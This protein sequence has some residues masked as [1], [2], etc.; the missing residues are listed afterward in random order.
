MKTLRIVYVDDWCGV[1]IDNT[2]ISEGHSIHESNL[3]GILKAHKFLADD[4]ELLVEWDEK[5]QAI[6]TNQNISHMPETYEELLFLKIET[7]PDN[8]LKEV[9]SS[10]EVG[11]GPFTVPIETVNKIINYL[12]RKNSG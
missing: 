2:L 4:V 9:A 8:L 12:E 7:S 10:W 11:G 1:Y 6:M 5:L 3:F